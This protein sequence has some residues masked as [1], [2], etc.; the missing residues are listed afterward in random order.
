MGLFHRDRSGRPDPLASLLSNRWAAVGK[1][2]ILSCGS[3]GSAVEMGPS[4]ARIA[5]GPI[6]D[7]D[8]DALGL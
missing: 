7:A 3:I 8:L 6:Q 1:E 5:V 4:R 2:K